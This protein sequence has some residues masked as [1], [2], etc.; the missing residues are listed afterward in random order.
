MMAK[1][2]IVFL[3]TAFAAADRFLPAIELSVAENF[4][5]ARE[6]VKSLCIHIVRSARSARQKVFPGGPDVLEAN[7]NLSILPMLTLGL[8]KSPVLKEGTDVKPDERAFLMCLVGTMG[9]ASLDLYIRPRVFVVSPLTGNQGLWD[10]ATNGIIEW[11]AEVGLSSEYLSSE[12]A[13]LIDN[14]V[15]LHLRLGKNVSPQ[16]LN[17]CFGIQSLD[18]I[19]GSTV[20]FFCFS[21]V[22]IGGF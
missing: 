9:V 15:M 8:C 3:F 20:S 22:C 6:R 17:E 1:E 7:P 10:A 4:L 19:Y 14:G 2:G 18:G 21:S 16:F 11:P 13:F 12:C 5:K